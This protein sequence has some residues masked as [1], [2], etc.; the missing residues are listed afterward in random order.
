MSEKKAILQRR[1]FLGTISKAGLLGTLGA[2]PI[3]G[4]AEQLSH[5]TTPKKEHVF[6]TLP[7]LQNPAPDSMCINWITNKPCYS[8]VA[9]GEGDKMDAKAH[10]TEDGF[11][12]A[13]NRINCIRLKNLK[14]VTT[15][16]YQVLSKEI[17]DFQPYKLTYGETISSAMYAFTTPDPKAK[18]ASWLVLNDIHDRP[19]S[20]APLLKLNGTDPYDFVFLNGDMFDYQ[21]GEQQIID[22]LVKPCTES[23]AT[24]KPFLFVRGNH[25]TRGR[26]ARELKIIFPIRARGNIF[27]LCKALFL[28]LFWIPAK[29]RKIHILCMPVL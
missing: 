23:F 22:H 16:R 15:Y 18:E 10:E 2:T 24:Q 14:P 1:Q 26:Y 3:G 21:T 19:E 29:T 6:L 12:T 7:Y 20:F 8:W 17:V 25:E 13:Y 11:V 27:H 5:I 4:F 28:I 9:Y